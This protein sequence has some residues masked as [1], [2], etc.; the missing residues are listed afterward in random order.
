MVSNFHKRIV[1]KI[2]SSSLTHAGGKLNLARIDHFLRQMVDLKNQGRD[3]LFV[4][5]GAIAAGMAEFTLKERPNSI[6]EQQGMAAIGQAQLMALYNKFLREYST[7]GAQILLTSSDLE[8]RH[9]YLNAYNTIESLLKNG[10]V[11]IIN[12]NDTVATQEIKF[13]DNDTL[14]A[15]VAGLTEADLLII[16]SDIEGLYNGNPRIDKNLQ[17]IRK[18]DTIDEEIEKLAG[19][20]GSKLGT[21]GMQTKIDA[22]R[23]AVNSG[24]TMVIGPG[25]RKNVL[26]DIINMLENKNDYMLGTTFLPVKD[27][28]SKR[29]HWLLYNPL[30]CGSIKI[31]QGAEKALLER[32]KSLLPGGILE[33]SGDF[34]E[35][36]PVSIINVNNLEIGK[37]LVNYT[38]KDIYK[39][40]GHHSD[41]IKQ[42][43]GFYNRADVIHRDN[44]VIK[45]NEISKGGE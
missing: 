40:K 18:I 30:V 13:G 12:E 44:M 27:S 4:S 43:L 39:I 29:K 17:V 11:P 41:E 20:R 38:S 28:L 14:S 16:L 22:A 19:G 31:D 36:E 1:I 10:A 6:P 32:G 15:K 45:N 37:G 34:Q 7:I 23:I 26:L 2:G 8:D 25:Q 5:S 21:G 3:I 42:I 35:N 33:V 24:I 9:R